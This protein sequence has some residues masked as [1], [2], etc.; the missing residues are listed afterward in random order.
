VWL[1]VHL[2]AAVLALLV[3]PVPLAQPVPPGP[4]APA[5]LAQS[6]LLVLPA[7]LVPLAPA[8]LA[9]SGLLVLP[10]PLVRPVLL[11]PAVLVVSNC[12]CCDTTRASAESAAV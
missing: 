12:R 6:V 5:V 9:R 3:P 1:Q 8:V 4:P 11:A 10:A 2:L 7:P